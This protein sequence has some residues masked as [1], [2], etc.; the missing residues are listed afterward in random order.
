LAKKKKYEN[1]EN[2]MAIEEAMAMC[3]DYEFHT[4]IAAEE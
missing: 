1:L 3:D 4:N 2:T